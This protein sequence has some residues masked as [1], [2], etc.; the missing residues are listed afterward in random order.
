MNDI[1][2]L[3][4]LELIGLAKRCVEQLPPSVHAMRALQSLGEALND[5]VLG[6]V[7]KCPGEAPKLVRPPL[8]PGRV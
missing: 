1:S 3:S 7:E 6:T 8:F 2:R 5:V 4:E